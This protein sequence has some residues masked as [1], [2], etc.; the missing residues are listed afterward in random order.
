MLQQYGDVCIDERS[1]FKIH[2]EYPMQTANGVTI[3]SGLLF[4]LSTVRHLLDSVKPLKI[5]S[6][7]RGNLSFREISQFAP[8]TINI[9]LT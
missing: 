3:L 8:Q 5:V 6:S 2:D 7:L 4:Q 1:V 9:F